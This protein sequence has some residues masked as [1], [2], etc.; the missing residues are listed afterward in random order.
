MS[1]TQW[2]QYQAADFY[3][4]ATQKLAKQYDKFLNFGGEYVEI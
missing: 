3:D 1:V 4:T 2:F